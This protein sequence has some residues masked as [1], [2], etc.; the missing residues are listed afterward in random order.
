M[1]CLRPTPRAYTAL[2]RLGSARQTIR[3]VEYLRDGLSKEGHAISVI[4]GKDMDVRE[5]ERVI[6]DFI[7]GKTRVLLASNLLAR[8]IDVCQVNIVIN[9]DI[10]LDADRQPDAETYVHR[11]GRCG[12]FGRPGVA[13]NL[14]HDEN[15]RRAMM[16]IAKA[17]VSNVTRI[18]AAD[19]KAQESLVRT[20][21]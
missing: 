14:V 2:L 9:Y 3:T 4:Y 17:I 15:S 18:D 10:P 19:T 8:G 21:K 13:I 1:R 20:L 7:A 11:I 16:I 6:G 5:R 12:R